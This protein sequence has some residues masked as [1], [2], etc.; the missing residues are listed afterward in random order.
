MDTCPTLTQTLSR[1][2]IWR[3]HTA[4]EGLASQPVV[5]LLAPRRG[6]DPVFETYLQTLVRF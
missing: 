4:A 3:T 2:G 1:K 5:F 6:E